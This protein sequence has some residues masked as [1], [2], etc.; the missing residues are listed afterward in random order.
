MSKPQ[1][2]SITLGVEHLARSR[3]FY[4]EGFGWKPHF[5]NDEIIYYDVGGLI[6]GTWLQMP[7]EMDMGRFAVERP[8]PISLGYGAASASDVDAMAVRLVAAGGWI[9][10]PGGR[11]PE[12]GYRA[13]V[14]DP[15]CHAWEIAWKGAWSFEEDP[16]T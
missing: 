12:G 13:Y 4:V 9:I 10:R 11:P 7:F 2:A 16:P 15:D 3:R 1:I 14:S 8:G 6:L 5:E